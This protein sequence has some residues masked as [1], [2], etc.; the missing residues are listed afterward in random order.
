LAGCSVGGN[1][2]EGDELRESLLRAQKSFARKDYSASISEYRRVLLL[3]PGR[4]PADAAY[5]HLGL[6]HADP[7]NPDKDLRRAV[8]CFNRVIVE[9]PQSPLVDQ[10]R[11]WVAVLDDSDKARQEL[12]VSKQMIEKSQQEIERSRQM[13][14]K[15][16]Q[17]AEKTRQ[18]MEKSK[19]VMERS[20][21]V[22]IEIEQKR[23]ERVR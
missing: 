8:E 11:I 10:A 15:A 19:Q 14:E 17:D 2:T 9:Y 13:I 12:E 7:N 20:K 18:E 4:A 5:F 23:R 16:Q 1:S 22:D 6:I 3:S 21:Q